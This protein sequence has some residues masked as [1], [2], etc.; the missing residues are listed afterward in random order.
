MKS[1]DHERLL[2]SIARLTEK[3][4]RESL[5]LC[6]MQTMFE[7]LSVEEITLY[8]VDGTRFGILV[9]INPEGYWSLNDDV[10]DPDSLT[11]IADDALFA[12]S[13]QKRR[14]QVEA[15]SSRIQRYAFPI[16]H[17]GQGVGI[18]CLE[19]ARDLTDDRRL[20]AGFLRIYQNYLALIH[21]N[22]C[23]KLTGL[24]NRKTFDER[25]IAILNGYRADL[26]Q[27][28]L[29]MTER[30]H[31]EGD[32]HYWL[33]VLDIDHFKRVND[34]FGH[35][36][37]DEVLLLMANLMR[38]SFRRGDLLFRYGGEEF[39]VVLKTADANEASNVLNR[40]RKAVELYDFPQVGQVTISIGYTQVRNSEMHT[41][42]IERADRGLYY[43][44]SNGRNQIQNYEQLISSGLLDTPQSQ[45]G[46]DVELF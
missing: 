8:Q 6:L 23:D 2:E 45:P 33:A 21:E 43:A 25:F 14:M 3:R 27:E 9:R 15:I 41:T 40:F 11:P 10:I 18:L 13:L 24:L 39:V 17:Q 7:L 16:L 38:R 32:P 20:I 46:S 22:A 28:R 37:G 36:Y 5:E 19:S 12:D 34:T 35:L 26:S 1:S 4:D 42:I 30:R 29:R 44:K 31:K